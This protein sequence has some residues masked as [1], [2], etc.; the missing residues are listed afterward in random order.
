MCVVYIGLIDC[1][2]E[3]VQRPY[4]FLTK[5]GVKLGT[6]F[7]ALQVIVVSILFVALLLTPN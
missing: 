5:D 1:L 2:L 6:L 7:N 3:V 4:D